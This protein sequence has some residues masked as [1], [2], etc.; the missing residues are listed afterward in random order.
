VPP[1][2][3]QWRPPPIPDSILRPIDC[4]RRVRNSASGAGTFW[5]EQNAKIE[6][7]PSGTTGVMSFGVRCEELATDPCRRW[8]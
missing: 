4:G 8:N 1:T 5:V 6:D 2:R 3:I 7:V